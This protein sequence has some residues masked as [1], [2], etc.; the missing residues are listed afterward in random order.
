MEKQARSSLQC[1]MSLIN[2][3]NI[4]TQLNL[5]F[6]ERE[7]AQHAGRFV[8]TLIILLFQW[9]QTGCRSRVDS[10]FGS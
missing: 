3:H 10:P 9:A 2:D 4:L 7:T 5:P 1:S 6:F 8:Q